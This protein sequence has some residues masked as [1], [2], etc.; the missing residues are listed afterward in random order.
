MDPYGREEQ[1]TGLEQRETKS[2]MQTQGPPQLTP[3]R[4][5]KLKWPTLVVPYGA[6]WLNQS[7]GIYPFILSPLRP[8]SFSHSHGWVFGGIS[9]W[10]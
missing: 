5:L 3:Q 7:Y 6:E 8:L 10:F 2:S 9:L 1:Q 4:A